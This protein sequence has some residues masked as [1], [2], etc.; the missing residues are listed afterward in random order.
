MVLAPTNT[1]RHVVRGNFFMAARYSLFSGRAQEKYSE[2]YSDF[3]ISLEN[4]DSALGILARCCLTRPG[5][6]EGEISH[7]QHR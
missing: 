1:K 5:G 7:F 4:P 2:K 6:L 3:D